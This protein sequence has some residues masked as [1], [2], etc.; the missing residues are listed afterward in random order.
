MTIH[1][2]KGLEFPLVFVV[3]LEEG[4]FPHSRSLGSQSEIE[5]ERRICYVGMTR[6]EKKLFLT[7]ALFRRFLFGE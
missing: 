1:Q 5:E 6:A 4:L 3:G 7:R 2:A